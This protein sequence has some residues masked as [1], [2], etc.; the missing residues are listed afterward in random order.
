MALHTDVRHC[1]WRRGEP[2]PSQCPRKGGTAVCWRARDDWRAD[3]WGHRVNVARAL[4]LL[5]SRPRSGCSACSR[6]MQSYRTQ[7]PLS[8]FVVFFFFG[9]RST[10]ADQTTPRDRF[11]LGSG[12]R[13]CQ[14]APRFARRSDTRHTPHTAHRTDDYLLVLHTRL[15]SF[16]S[17]PPPL[18]VTPV[19]TAARRIFFQF[20]YP[21]FQYFRALSR[22]YLSP[23]APP[24]PPSPTLLSRSFPSFVNDT[25]SICASPFSVCT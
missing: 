6:E 13:C 22:S 8:A 19:I 15:F 17:S 5:P 2:S 21:L 14:R 9:V 25:H 11:R 1:Q 12:D 7:P 10:V 20:S 18:T 4:F 16:T 24:P 23:S 3:G